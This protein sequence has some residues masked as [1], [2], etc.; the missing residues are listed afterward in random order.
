MCGLDGSGKTTLIKRACDDLEK[1]AAANPGAETNSEMYTSTPFINMEKIVL[2]ETSQPCVVY[3]M[4]GQGRYRQN[5]SYF[6]PEVDGVFFVV[7]STDQDRLQIV[8]EMLE[9]M[10]KHPGFVGR[11]IPFIIVNN[12]T[13]CPEAMDDQELRKYVQ[14]DKLKSLNYLKYDVKSVIGITGYNVDKC[15]KFFEQYSK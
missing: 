3:D 11:Q 2:P 13:D 4:S 12:K 8:Q 14:M 7:D 6:Y 15:F 9:E 5:W 1:F 10:A